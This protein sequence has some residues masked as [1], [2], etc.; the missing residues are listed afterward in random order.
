M[1]EFKIKGTKKQI[2]R[3]L[4]EMENGYEVSI[5]RYYDD[6]PME[7]IEFMD[8]ELFDSC[9]RTNYLVAI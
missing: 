3:V 8:H 2:V 4:K 9:L 6:Y 7:T 1:K 5:I